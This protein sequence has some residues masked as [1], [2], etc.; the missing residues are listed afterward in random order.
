MKLWNRRRKEESPPPA[1]VQLRPAER[2]PFALMDGYV[3]LHEPAFDLYR[4]IREGIPVVDAAILKLVRLAGGVEVTCPDKGVEQALNDFLR[5]VPAG[6][7]QRGIQAF[8]DSYLDCLLTCGRAVGEIVPSRDG[9]EIAAVLCGKVSDIQVREGDSPLDVVLALQQPDG[10]VQDLP[11]QELLLF[12]PYHPSPEHPYGVSLLHSMPFLSGIL[13]KIYQTLGANWERAGN[14]RFAVVY[15]PEAEADARQVRERGELLARRWSEA[16]G[17]TRS[18]S[19]RDFVSVGDVEIKVIGAECDIPDCQAPVRLI[20]EQLIAQTGIP[21]FLLG[22]SWSTTE[23]MS[24]QQADIM[25]SELTALR[26]TLTPVVER[27]CS[28]WLHLHG[29]DCPFQVVW[30]EINLQ[31]QVEEARAALYHQQAQQLEGQAAQGQ[32]QPEKEEDHGD[33]TQAGPGPG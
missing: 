8:L 11:R 10:S 19:V 32:K 26:R 23:R 21:P 2:H 1:P 15:K 16:M 30:E 13:M 29:R 7:N 3:P 28:L 25:T 12:T 9:R 18:G 31:D 20:L 33:S 27:V 24:S 4:A 22:L 14:V 17:S 5:T 6:W